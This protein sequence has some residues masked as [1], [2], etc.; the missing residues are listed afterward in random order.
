[1]LVNTGC[2]NC[3]FLHPVFKQFHY[4]C[5][6]VKNFTNTHSKTSFAMLIFHTSFLKLQHLSVFPVIVDIFK[7]R[8][9]KKYLYYLMFLRWGWELYHKA[10][11]TSWN[12][13]ERYIHFSLQFP[14]L[15]FLLWQMGGLWALLNVGLFFLMCSFTSELFIWRTNR[16]QIKNLVN[17]VACWG[18]EELKL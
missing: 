12:I 1:M 8:T 4:C 9:T 7:D 5:T 6:S 3:C 10:C 14:H 11:L 18:R 16:K 13:F 15:F 2:I 17:S